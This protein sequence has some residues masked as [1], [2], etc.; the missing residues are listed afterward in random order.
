MTAC[1]SAWRQP[2]LTSPRSLEACKLSGVEPNELLIL[3]LEYFCRTSE[4]NMEVVQLRYHRFEQIRCVAH[5]LHQA[6]MWG[7]NA[8]W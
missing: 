3:P 4:E 2:Y 7:H 6:A 5:A 8:R 1:L